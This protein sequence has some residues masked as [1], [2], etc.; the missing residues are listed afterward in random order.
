MKNIGAC[1]LQFA[2]AERERE[3]ERERRHEANGHG[4]YGF[5]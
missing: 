4:I 3:L 5:H 1:I 2:H